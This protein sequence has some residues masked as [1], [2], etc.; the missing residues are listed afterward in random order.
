M[1]RVIAIN[2]TQ[3]SDLSGHDLV[4]FFGAPVFLLWIASNVVAA[5]IRGTAFTLETITFGVVPQAAFAGILTMSLVVLISDHRSEWL[6]STWK[7]AGTVAGA[8]LPVT[9]VMNVTVEVSLTEQLL[10][11]VANSLGTGFGTAIGLYLYRGRS[12][13]LKTDGDDGG[14]SG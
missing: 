6:H 4:T 2:G 10:A 9:A 3:H 5:G 13:A 12:S 14:T 8:T 1:K 7:T 11:L